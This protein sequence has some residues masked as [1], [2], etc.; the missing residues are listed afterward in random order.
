ML[1]DSS[2]SSDQN[3]PGASTTV[4]RISVKVPPFWKDNPSIWFRQ[5]ESQFINSGISADLT[6]YHIVV[7]HIETD[8]LSQ[9][10][11]IIESP[12]ERDAYESLKR[13]IIEAFSDSE[14]KKL[15]K[16]LQELD[17]GDKRPS[18]L[19]RQMRDLAG[20]GVNDKLLKSLWLQRLPNTM[21]AILATS[22]EALPQI[23]IMA[24]KIAD[25]TCAEI[26]SSRA[27]FSP[28]SPSNEAA[29]ADMQRQ[30]STLTE[31]VDKLFSMMKSRGRSHFRTNRKTISRSPSRDKLCWYHAKFS[32][33]ATKCIKPCSFQPLNKTAER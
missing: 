22:S 3:N 8:I 9:V 4:S 2:D 25:V 5:L 32:E 16:L 6:K 23:A 12:P 7:G 28:P 13:R 17:L 31:K 27:Q 33:N 15:K 20:Q 10:S 21:Q 11:D 26:H 19:L 14:E 18:V 30:I 24:D 29:M 1:G